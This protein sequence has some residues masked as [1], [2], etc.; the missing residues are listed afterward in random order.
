MVANLF[1]FDRKKG[2]I[3]MNNKIRYCI[4][5]FPVKMEHLKRF[6]EIVLEAIKENFLEKG[7]PQK[8]VDNYLKKA[9]NITYTKTHSRSILGAMNQADIFIT[10]FWNEY[11]FIRS[12]KVNQVYLNKRI[13]QLIVSHVTPNEMLKREFGI[14]GKSLDR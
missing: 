10:V 13:S 11:Y 12:E 4:V 6:D 9:R 8:K 7:I 5:L 14:R 3:L 1:T 2:V